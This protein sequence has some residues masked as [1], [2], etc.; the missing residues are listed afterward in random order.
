MYIYAYNVS[1]VLFRAFGLHAGVV[2][3]IFAILGERASVSEPASGWKA[4]WNV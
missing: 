1:T 3:P 4:V 2:I